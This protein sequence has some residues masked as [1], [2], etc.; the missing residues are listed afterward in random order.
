MGQRKRIK[1]P[2]LVTNAILALVSTNSP[3]LLQWGRCWWNPWDKASLIILRVREHRYYT[4]ITTRIPGNVLSNYYKWFYLLTHSMAIRFCLWTQ[5][6]I[7]TIKLCPALL[8]EHKICTI[9][10]THTLV[11]SPCS[12]YSF[13]GINKTLCQKLQIFTQ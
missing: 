4:L 6:C 13:V 12:E 7:S 10:S 8:I 11:F 3:S 2:V 9:R 1:C 5:L